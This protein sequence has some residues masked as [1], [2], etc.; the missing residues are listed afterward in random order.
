MNNTLNLATKTEVKNTFAATLK[1]IGGGFV[2][3]GWLNFD[4]AESQ[5]GADFTVG[6]NAVDHKGFTRLVAYSSF[7]ELIL[8]GGQYQIKT[9]IEYYDESLIQ[10]NSFD[11]FCIG[12]GETLV[13]KETTVSKKNMSMTD[14]KKGGLNNHLIAAMNSI[15][16]L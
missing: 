3:E 9:E 1:R 6:I 13:H 16:H 5:L 8:A 14:F 11:A 2:V 4:D 10:S 15:N 12:S 7:S